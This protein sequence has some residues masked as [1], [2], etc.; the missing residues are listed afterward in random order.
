V[1]A[2]S[3]SVHELTTNALK[4]GALSRPAGT[5]QIS[6]TRPA[7]EDFVIVDWIERGG[8]PVSPPKREGFGTRLLSTLTNKPSGEGAGTSYNLNG[9]E[10]RLIL[11][12]IPQGEQ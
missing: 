6:W 4:Y 10:H 11:P 3:L 1:V 5:V 7:D 2:L 9:L 8:P 12:F